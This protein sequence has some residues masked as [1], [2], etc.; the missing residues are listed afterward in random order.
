MQPFIE[1]SS[2]HA[3]PLIVSGVNNS[4]LIVKLDEHFFAPKY[5]TVICW[6]HDIGICTLACGF[7]L[8]SLCAAFELFGA[9][10]REG[11]FCH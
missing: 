6:V 2:H 1:Q 5:M 4:T 7:L 10:V 3:D 9:G 8:E 11:V